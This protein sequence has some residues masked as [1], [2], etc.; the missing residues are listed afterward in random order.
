MINVEKL[1]ILTADSQKIVQ[2]ISFNISAGEKAVLS[3]PSGCGKSSILRSIPGGMERWSGK[4]SVFNKELTPHS[5]A[6]IRKMICCIP[7]EPKLPEGTVASYLESLRNFSGNRS[8]KWK[9]SD[10]KELLEK[11]LLSKSILK[12]ETS[13]ISGG[14][15]QRVA[16]V[17]SL[18]LKRPIILADE[19]TSAL[20]SESKR[21]VMDLIFTQETTLLSVAH[22]P[23]WIERCSRTIPITS[24]GQN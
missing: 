14:E 17:G 13:N 9:K 4:I 11:T 24:A 19:I 7:Q 22:D 23:L 21:A 3:G 12:K 5:A 6:D 1:T 18:L 2:E 10:L 16:I 15:R 20:D 8:V